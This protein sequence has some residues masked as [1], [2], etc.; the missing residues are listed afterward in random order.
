MTEVEVTVHN[1][2]IGNFIDGRDR[3]LTNLLQLFTH[4]QDSEQFSTIF[5][6]IFEDNIVTEQKK[7][8]W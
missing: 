8:Y 3:F 4:S 5:V 6:I 2:I 7:T 1:S